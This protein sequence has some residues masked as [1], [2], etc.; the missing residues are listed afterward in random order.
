MADFVLI[1]GDKANFLP[2][3]G[4]AVVVVQPGTLQGSG[5]ATLNGKKMCVD[6][7]EKKVEV[8]GCSYVTPQYSSIPGTGTL[9]IAALAGNQKATKTSTG[10]KAVLL[11]GGNF[12]ASFEVQSPAQPPPGSGSPD[13]TPKYSGMGTFITTNTKFQGV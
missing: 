13:A 11:K 10:G 7:D 6:G 1:E 8:A 3:F 12:T 2:N 5:P 4:P 9:K